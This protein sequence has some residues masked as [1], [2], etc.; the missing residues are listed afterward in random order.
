MTESMILQLGNI[1]FLHKPFIVVTVRTWFCR[2]L[3]IGK[4]VIVIINYFFKGFNIVSNSLFIGISRQEFFCLWRVDDQLCMF[5]LSFYD[6]DAFY[7]P[8]NG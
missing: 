2:T 1:K 6:I 7:R 5:S 4:N 8:V 3:V